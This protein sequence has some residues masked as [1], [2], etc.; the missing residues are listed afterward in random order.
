V[1]SFG[2]ATAARSTHDRKEWGASIWRYVEAIQATLDAAKAGDITLPE[3]P[4]DMPGPRKRFCQDSGKIEP[5]PQI[6]R[7]SQGSGSVE[8]R[9]DRRSSNYARALA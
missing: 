6:K 7:L 2:A 1:E 4:A 5:G 9:R 8:T 3:I